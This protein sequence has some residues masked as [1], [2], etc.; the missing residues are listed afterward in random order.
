[1]KPTIQLADFRSA[2]SSFEARY[3]QAVTRVGKSGWLILG[4][5]VEAFEKELATF[6][7]LP[8]AVGVANGLDALEIAFRALGAK[9]GDR[10]LT[11]PLSA[12]A[13]TLAI[14]RVG[15]VPVF[16]DV[17]DSGLIDLDSA[18]KVL[19]S[20]GPCRF[21]VP[22]H[23][24]GHAM[25]LEALTAFS[26]KH[27]LTLIEDCAQAI[28]ATSKGRPVGSASVACATSFYP[29]KNLGAFGDGGAL[30]TTSTT[31]RDAARALR[32]YGQTD[33]YVHDIVGLN[34]RLDEL[35]AALLRSVQL[36]ELAAQTRRRVAIAERYLAGLKHPR[37]HVVPTPRDSGSVWHLFPLIVDG[38]REAFRAHLK[39]QGVATALHYP[40][41]IP[42]QKATHAAGFTF[43]RG[44]FPNAT[45]FAE[46]EVSIPIHPFLSDD[47]CQRVVDAVNSYGGRS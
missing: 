18:A 2:W 5:E 27:G 13:T 16:A 4:A 40:H 12:Y 24:Y 20:E 9:A 29:T 30:L 43:K 23:L 22:V 33:K 21:F 26:A 32:D 28:G 31:V 8:F 11:T 45:R 25:S 37:V 19:A 38:D 3:L 47:D 15:G 6:W 36:P 42:D 14:L 35:Q 34:S 1:V 41:L 7:G 46:H 10:F 44:Q 17:D 39:A